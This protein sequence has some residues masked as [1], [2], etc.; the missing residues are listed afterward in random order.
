MMESLPNGVFAASLIPLKKNLSIDFGKLTGHGVKLLDGGCDGL[1]LMGTTGEANSFDFF[2]RKQILK[3]TLKSGVNPH[4]ILV[5]TGCCSLSETISLTN[6]SLENGVNHVLVLPPFYYI[7]VDDADLFRYFEELI[8]RTNNPALRIYL[9]H[10]PKM[11]GLP[12]SHGLIGELLSSFPGIV[13]GIKDSSGDWKNMSTM[14]NQ[15]SDFRVFSGTEIYF[16]DLL[17][18]GGAGIIS[19]TV[20]IFYKLATEVYKNASN[21]Y[22]EFLQQRLTQLRRLIEKHPTI[23]ILKLLMSQLENDDDWLNTRPPLMPLTLWN[24]NEIKDIISEINK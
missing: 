13:A 12:F 9:Y 22:G 6:H 3:E 24:E 5:G 10:F 23:P 17:K 15:F 16:V 11:T 8:N 2:E 7:G 1:V 4:E 20:N 14:C 19:A 21:A 18:K